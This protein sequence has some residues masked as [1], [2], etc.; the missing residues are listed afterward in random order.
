MRAM[1]FRTSRSV[2]VCSAVNQGKGIPI[3]SQIIA[4][5]HLSPKIKA[6]FPPQL[7]AEPVENVITRSE[8][9]RLTKCLQN[10]SPV[11]SNGIFRNKQ[12]ML[13]S[14]SSW[15]FSDANISRL[16]VHTTMKNPWKCR[17]SENK[18][19]NALLLFNSTQLKH[20]FFVRQH[21][22]SCIIYFIHKHG[23]VEAT[24]RRRTELNSL[25][26]A[27]FVMIAEPSAAKEFLRVC[28]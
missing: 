4:F 18:K 1:T 27:K 12:I 28:E 19:L 10:I 11:E 8:A 3:R 13:E 14:R 25:H 9:C 5:T 21:F 7:T 26:V 2:S 16:L 17:F 22:V 23:K 20:V 6:F 24:R 15:I